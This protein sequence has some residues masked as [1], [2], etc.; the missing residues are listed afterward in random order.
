ML[1]L[2][3]LATL[4]LCGKSQ[5]PGLSGSLAADEPSL[6]L[7]PLALGTGGLLPSPPFCLQDAAPSQ[8][9]MGRSGW[10]EGAKRA[11][12]P[13]PRRWVLVGSSQ[14]LGATWG[15]PHASPRT[16]SPPP[17]LPAVLLQRRLAPHLRRVP[18]PEELGDD[19]SSLRGQVSGHG[20]PDRF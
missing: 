7:T 6:Q 20:G 1:Q 16:V 14:G 9:R 17:D 12:T 5:F 15:D 19:S 3:L 11:L 13:G 18:D 10:S 2:L 8:C 4:T